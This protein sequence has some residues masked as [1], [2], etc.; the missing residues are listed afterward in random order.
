MG[1]KNPYF[2][3]KPRQ[4][5]L[6]ARYNMYISIQ[7]HYIQEIN[8]DYNFEQKHTSQSHKIKPSSKTYLL[9]AGTRHFGY[10]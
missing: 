2:L 5:P 1:K 6:N 7:I 4:C 10:T 3:I 8:F 9:N